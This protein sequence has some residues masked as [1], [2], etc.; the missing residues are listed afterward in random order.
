MALGGAVAPLLLSYGSVAYK[1]CR[2]AIQG[3]MQV[4]FLPIDGSS[5][6]LNFVAVN[7]RHLAEIAHAERA[8]RTEREIARSQAALAAA[9]LA[10]LLN[11][12]LR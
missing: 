10:N 3:P 2:P 4:T 9:R 5:R 7:V 8:E 12:A 6:R 11:S 1:R